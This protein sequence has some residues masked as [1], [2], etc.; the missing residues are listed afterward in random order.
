M[1]FKGTQLYP[2]GWSLSYTS[3]AYSNLNK[4]AEPFAKKGQITFS[5]NVRNTGTRTGDEVVRLYVTHVGSKVERPIKELKAF[6]R[7]RLEPGE[8]TTVRFTLKASDWAC[9]SSEKGAWDVEA[10]LISVMIG[11]SSADVKLKTMVPV[12]P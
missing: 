11:D 7:V 10:D 5:L 12:E 8:Q 3:F 9:W 1:Y 2:F 6:R 4:S